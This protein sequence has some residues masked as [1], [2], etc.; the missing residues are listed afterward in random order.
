MGFARQH[1]QKLNQHYIGTEHILLGL[2]DEGNGVAA[3][4]LRKF[5]IDL[6]RLQAAV[7]EITQVGPTM[8]TM[9]QLPFTPRCKR[10]LELAGE[11]ATDLR[12]NYIGT[13]HLLLGAIRDPESA[14]FAALEKCD[15]DLKAIETEIYATLGATMPTEEH[16][17]GTTFDDYQKFTGTVAIYPGANTGSFDAMT[18]VALK[19]AGECGEFAEKL[20]KRMRNKNTISALSRDSMEPEVRLDLAKELGDRLWYISQAATELGYSLSEIA[21]INIAKLT[22]RQERGVLDGEGDNR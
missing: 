21:Q 11:A 6:E 19:G 8:I 10:M 17:A 13:E 18:Y 9:G 12:H 4:T 22:S 1:A 14:S 16:P 3:N 2:M 15:V 7:R 20:G 5:H